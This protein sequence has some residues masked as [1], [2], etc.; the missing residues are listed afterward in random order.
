MAPNG[1]GPAVIRRVELSDGTLSPQVPSGDADEEGRAVMETGW[2]TAVEAGQYLMMRPARRPVGRAEG[3][4]AARG[5]RAPYSR[6]EKA[7]LG[8]LSVY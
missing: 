1:V 7:R 5:R 3:K 4:T 8:Q 6:G 2:E